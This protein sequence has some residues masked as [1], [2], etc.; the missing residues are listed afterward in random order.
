[1][2]KLYIFGLTV[3]ILGFS[4]KGFSQISQGGV[5]LSFQNTQFITGQ[6]PIK[7]MT[8]VDVQQLLAQDSANDLNKDIPWRFGWNI[9][10]SYDLTTSGVWDVL[11]N[12]G[13]LWRLGIKC[14]GALSINLTFDDYHLPPG[15]TFFEYNADR[16]QVIGAFT[17]FNNRDDSV[18]ATTLVKGEEIIMEYYEPKGTAFQGRVHLNRV[19]HGYRDA[20]TYVKGFGGSG[21][22]NNNV[23]CPRADGWQNQVRSACMLVSGGSGFCSGA[24]VNNTSQDGTPYIL[25]ANHCYSSPNTWIFWFNWESPTCQNPPSSPPYNSISG[26]TLNARNAASDF[27][28]VK[29]SSTP[30]A[31]FSVYYAGWNRQDTAA[32]SGA[33][34]HHPSGDIKKISYSSQAFASGTWSGTPADS[35]WQVFWSD[36]VTEPGSSGSPI[37]DQYNLLVGQLH[38]GPSACGASQLWDFYGK[39]AMSWNYGGT[40]A[41]RLHDWLDP[42]GIAGDTLH[43]WDPNIVPIVH[44][45]A[46]TNILVTTSTLNGTVNPNGW[47]TMYHFDYGTTTSFGDTTS[48]QSAGSGSSTIPV[49]SNITGVTQGTQYFFRLVGKASTSTYYGDTLSFTTALPSLTV[50]PPNQNVGT[51]AGITKFLVTSNVSWTVISGSSW[52]T[53]TSSGTGTDTIFASYDQNTSITP[54]VAQ[55]TVTGNGVPPVTVT[56]SQAGVPIL[57][58][59][60]PPDTNV[61][62]ALGSTRFYVTSNTNWTVTGN[63]SWI[64]FTGSGSGSDTIHVTFTEN[65][66][67]TPRTAMIKVHAA[68]IDSVSAT[69]TQAGAPLQLN[70][71]PLNKDVTSPLGSTNYTVTSNTNWTVATDASWC[72]VTQGGSGNGTIVADYT[73]NKTAQ[74]RIASI[75]VTVT[76]LPVQTVTLTQAKAPNG[77]SGQEDAGLKIIPN[78]TKGLFRIVPAAGTTGILDLQVIDMNGRCILKKQFSGE[79]EYEAD[80]SSAEAG[81]YQLIIKTEQAMTVKKLVIVK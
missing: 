21:S 53:V 58:N 55:I 16:T 60:T 48:S 5:P 18:F 9:Y 78:P 14:P 73:E 45:L 2:K 62:N 74:A 69:L 3:A 76:G 50:T 26:A 28:L 61:T 32:D 71:T 22:C 56:V 72:T 10:V 57:L 41:T 44:T 15:A 38:G 6:V 64:T 67:I 4:L 63:S 27:C 36:G 42:T 20:F 12:G 49:N 65:T 81:T 70:V 77:I 39:F 19:T 1:M 24:L 30:P 17:D 11:P 33:G 75:S 68:G 80:L 47:A 66:A 34:I 25:T 43:G 79:K 54:R 8:A 13:R 37:F 35:H 51:P 29:M 40:A 7:V 59:I 52:C 31:N 46:A 23:H